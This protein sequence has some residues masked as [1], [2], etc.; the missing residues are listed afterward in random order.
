MTRQAVTK[1]LRV[2]EEAGIVHGVR[3]GREIRFQFD[4]E[5]MKEIKQYLDLV[6]EEWDQ[7]LGRLKSFIEG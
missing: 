7:A 2:L 3:E 5:P 4:P 6:S 1:H